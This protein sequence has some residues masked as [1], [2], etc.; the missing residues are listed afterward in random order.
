M[1]NFLLWLFYPAFVRLTRYFGDVG[2]ILY[3]GGKGDSPDAPDYTPLAAA[4]EKAAQIGADLG[5]EQLAENKRQ[6]DQNMQV[7]APIV[8]AQTDLMKQ[9]IE[10]GNDYYEYMKTRQRPVEDAL[11]AEAMAAGS[12]AKQAEAAARAEAD[13]MRG[14]TKSANV[15]ARQGLRYGLAPSAIKSQAGTLSATQASNIVGATGAAREQEK[16]TGY[17]KKLDVSGLYRGLPGASQGAYSVANNAGNSAVGNQNQTSAQYL[18]GMSAGTNTIMQGQQ[19]KINGLGSILNSQTSIYNNSQSG[20]MTGSIIG[21]LG[22][23][24][25]SAITKWSDRR[26]KENIVPV[27]VDEDSGLTLYEFNYAALPGRR[28][29]GV[30]ADEVEKVAPSAVVYDENGFASV[31]YSAIGIDMVEVTA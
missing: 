14:L 22:G 23:I 26:L 27:G 28:F 5:R 19:Q 11:N 20:D 17:A 12:E 10:Q 24:G 15:I 18:N 8:Q 30:M 6:Y 3:G 1:R 4:S 13:S 9:S 25:A 2:F 7:A 29:I 21:A 31:D 16:N